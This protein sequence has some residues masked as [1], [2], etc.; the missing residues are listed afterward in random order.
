MLKKSASLVALSVIM[1]AIAPAQ[2]NERGRVQDTVTPKRVILEP[3]EIRAVRAGEKSPFTQTTL[4]KAAL[5]KN[6]LGQDIPFLLNQTPSVVVHSDAGNG[7]GYTGIRIRG[8]DATR[9]NI[10]LNGIPYNDAESQGVFFVNLP[11]FASSV[12]SI[13]VQ[14]GIGTSTSG[15]GAFGASIHMSTN[16]TRTVPYAELNNSYGSF[17]SWKNTVNVGT[18]LIGNH[19]TLDGRL[20]RITS[21]G[22]IDR[23]SSDLRSFF[24]SVAWITEKSTLR[25]NVFSGKE[26]TYQAWYGVDEATLET[27]RRFNAAGTEKPGEPYDNETDNY[28]Q[29]HYQLFYNRT[30]NSR[31]NLQSAFFYTRGLGYYEQYKAGQYY[32]D[33]GLAYPMYGGDTVFTTD[34]IRQLWLD[35]HYY[36][37]NA[38]LQYKDEQKEII[39]GGGG[40]RYLGDHYGKVIWASNGGVE[41]DYRW[42]N[43][44]AFKN[45][46]YAFAKWQQQWRKRITLFAD[47]QYRYVQYDL[48]GFRNNPGL[49]VSNRWNF[50]NPK[51]GVRYALRNGFAYISWAMANKEPNRDDFEAGQENQPR[52]ERLQN[53]EL[54]IEKRKP[55]WS[56][57][58]TVYYMRYR[59]QL[60]LTGKINDVGAYARTNIPNSYRLGLELQG[61][62][63]PVKWFNGQGNLTLSRNR[64]RDYT[65]YTDD[66]DDGGQKTEFFSNTD[67]SFSPTITGAATLSFTPLRHLEIALLPKY[68]SRQYLDNTTR[69]S[70]SLDPYFVQD[71]RAIWTIP[72]PWIRETT[73]TFQLNNMFNARYEP[74]GYTFSYIYNGV[75]QAAN[76][77]YPMAGLNFMVGLSLKM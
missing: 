33:Y 35:N 59:D 7:V 75:T 48:N 16:E 51:A 54:G 9:I 14:R 30:L 21:D 37:M 2:E 6:N 5:G 74:N 63:K 25:A 38:S 49:F 47:I 39:A 42:Y 17:N 52:P 69:K 72:Q 13:Q 15:T 58:A 1:A 4:G 31:L 65:A 55:E 56:W 64:I 26:K 43:Q 20:S 68:V 57:G 46:I 73:L 32:M 77:Y 61:G 44:D 60:V 67:I 19:F 76:Y 27:N 40:S 34:L 22:Y 8:T 62:W 10:T 50:L 24:L 70:R 53:L 23:A 71:L 11:D 3:I 36:G 41:K 29:T 18:G 12:N 28:Q 45:E 66:Y